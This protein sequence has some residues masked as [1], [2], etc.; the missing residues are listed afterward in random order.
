MANTYKPVDMDIGSGRTVLINIRSDVFT[1][2]GMTESTNTG[3][4]VVT[5]RRKAHQR[6]NYDGANDSTSETNISV[7][8]S[9]WQ[10]VKRV[11]A[12]GRGKAVRVPTGLTSGANDNPRFT[13]IRFPGNANI[14]SISNFLHEKCT[15]NKPDFFIMPSGTRYPV[16]NV[17][18][19][20]NAGEADA[21]A[22]GGAGA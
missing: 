20:V 16:V 14:A 13:T 3:D 1:R 19:D 21:D 18:G 11:A 8:V 7:G 5:R 15:T 9:T 2:F 6:S 12:I 22:G 4:Q 17:T 10:A